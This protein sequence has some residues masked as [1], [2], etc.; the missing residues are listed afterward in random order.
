MKPKAEDLAKVIEENIAYHSAK[1]IGVKCSHCGKYPITPYYQLDD[2]LHK[3]SDEIVEF[4]GL[5]LYDKIS[6]I[7]DSTNGELSGKKKKD[8][9]MIAKK[10]I[11]EVYL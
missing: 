11:D 9:M 4:L 5:N 2:S 8:S 10:I 3:I 1:H 6:D 7:L